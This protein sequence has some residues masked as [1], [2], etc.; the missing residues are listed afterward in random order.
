MNL[1]VKK[2]NKYVGNFEF[3]KQL[4]LESISDDD[5]H[6]CPHG[7][8]TSL[9]NKHTH[10]VCFLRGSKLSVMIAMICNAC[11]ARHILPLDLKRCALSTVL[12]KALGS[13]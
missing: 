5:S 13:S 12:F 6:A 9:G 7:H 3:E 2:T 11:K 8:Q 1:Y 10:I 4:G